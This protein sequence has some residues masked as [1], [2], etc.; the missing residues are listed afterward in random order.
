MIIL[1]VFFTANIEFTESFLYICE[2]LIT[3]NSVYPTPYLLEVCNLKKYH[4]GLCVCKY[5]F[6]S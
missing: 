1:G 4:Y 2:I 5:R 6:F 3:Y